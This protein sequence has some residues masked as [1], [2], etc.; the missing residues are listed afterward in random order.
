[1]QGMADT[2]NKQNM[3]NNLMMSE[4]VHNSKTLDLHQ[5]H[6]GKPPKDVNN[7]HAFSTVHRYVY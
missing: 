6:P 2:L 1:M 5:P 4:H 7:F 3:I